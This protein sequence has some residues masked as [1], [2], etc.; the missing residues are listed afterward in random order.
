[1]PRLVH[2]CGCGGADVVLDMHGRFLH[3]SMYWAKYTIGPRFEI[4]GKNLTFAWLEA[5]DR[6]VGIHAGNTL[7]GSRH[8]LL[9]FDGLILHALTL[10]A[11]ILH[12]GGTYER[13][14]ESVL[15][16][17]GV[18][19]F[20]NDFPGRD[21]L[22]NVCFKRCEVYRNGVFDHSEV[23]VCQTG[24]VA[25]HR[26]VAGELV[27]RGSIRT[28]RQRYRDDKNEC[29]FHEAA[30]TT[31]S[32]PGLSLAWMHNLMSH[33]VHVPIFVMAARRGCAPQP[34]VRP[35]TA[36]PR[37]SFPGARTVI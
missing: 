5:F 17:I 32:A 35:I 36:H 20:E 4:D 11:V 23:R 2:R 18:L 30:N 15:L 10:H 25:E 1:M 13:D 19:D 29:G 8:L 21:G 3:S 16:R 9:A 31:K 26:G 22:R 14:L 6:P 34:V 12:V 37:W 28:G 24:G 33:F 7:V 27:R